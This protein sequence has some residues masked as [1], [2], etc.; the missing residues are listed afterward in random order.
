MDTNNVAEENVVETDTT[1]TS[2]PQVE[3]PITEG[4]TVQGE[5]VQPPVVE[6][7]KDPAMNEEQ[8]RAFQEMRQENKRLK[9]KMEA[10]P[11]GESAFNQFRVTT[12]PAS[13]APVDVQQFTDQLTGETN[14]YGYNQAQ[15]QREQQIIQQAKFEAQQTTQ[16]LLDENNA[17]QK[18]P[19]LFADPE[20]EQD[21][22][23]KWLAAKLR[24]QNASITQIADGFARK[25]KQTASKAEKV[26]AERILNEVSDK[27]NAGLTAQGQSSQGAKLAISQENS[28][29]LRLNTRQGSLDAV[30]ARIS[31]IPW[32]N[33]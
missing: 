28:D 31:Q 9:E 11:T 24:G 1:Q 6:D 32:A 22:A 19:A 21:I 27:E 15:Q 7:A 16:E 18:F 14:W 2:S 13:Q 17:R 23:D 8:R 26:G 4:K 25:L 29:K 3:S 20:V 5:T 33:K 10:R 12:P 30:T